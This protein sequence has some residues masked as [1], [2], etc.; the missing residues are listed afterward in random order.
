MWLSNRDYCQLMDRC[1]TA[2]LPSKFA[3]LNGMSA[4]T[5]MLWDLEDTR[6]LVGFEPQDDV[7]RAGV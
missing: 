1:L 6:R 7:T 5:G 4:N 3:I 2:T